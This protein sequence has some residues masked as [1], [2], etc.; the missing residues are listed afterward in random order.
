M[1][2]LLGLL[3]IRTTET[4]HN[5]KPNGNWTSS[6]MPTRALPTRGLDKSRTRQLTNAASSSTCSFNY[7]TMWT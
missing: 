3:K 7:V 1:C 4:K 5:P 2:Y 6:I